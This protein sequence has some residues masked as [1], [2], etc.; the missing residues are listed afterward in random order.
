[1]E[2]DPY[3]F[4]TGAKVYNELPIETIKINDFKKFKLSVKRFYT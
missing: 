4:F 1:M 2:K 3:F